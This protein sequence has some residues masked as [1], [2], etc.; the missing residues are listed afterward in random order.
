MCFDTQ[1]KPCSGVFYEMIWVK[2][3][4]ESSKK[5]KLKL[6][7]FKDKKLIPFLKNISPSTSKEE[8]EK[9]F[10]QFEQEYFSEQSTL[11]P[12]KEYEWHLFLQEI[13]KEKDRFEN[14]LNTIQ[15]YD[16]QVRE[17]EQ[18]RINAEREIQLKENERKRLENLKEQQQLLHAQ[19]LLELEKNKK[20]EK[21]RLFAEYSQKIK[22]N[23][24]RLLLAN[25][26]QK[27]EMQQLINLEQ[28][29]YVSLQ[30]QMN[31]QIRDNQLTIQNLNNTINNFRP[32][33]VHVHRGG[34]G[35]NIF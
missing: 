27:K 14:Q 12:K 15:G 31:Q 6:N 23:E 19:Q 25:D 29:K 7:S 1:H 5:C 10:T 4:I 20:L 18:K 16:K 35:C 28:S 30:N 13:E 26:K 3:E 17:Q 32:Q 21:E 11:G 34:G 9:I 33:V 8:I 24:N 2:N 22:E